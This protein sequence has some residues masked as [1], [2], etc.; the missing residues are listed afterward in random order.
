MGMNDLQF[1]R[2]APRCSGQREAF[3]EICCQLASRSLPPDAAYTRLHG[4]GGDGGVECFA[5]LPDGSRIGWQAKY[6]FRI[7]PLLTQASESLA[8]ALRVH[9]TLTRYIVCFPFNLTGPTERR[10]QSGQERFAEWQRERKDEATAEGRDLTIEAWPESRLTSLLLDHD[11]SG[12]IREFFFNETV[13]SE[14]WFQAHLASVR[15]TAGPRYTPDLSIETD[16]AKWFSAFGRTESWSQALQQRVQPCRT[17]HERLASAADEARPGAWSGTWPKGSREEAQSVAAQMERVLDQCSTLSTTDDPEALSQC[18]GG[19]EGLLGALRS[20]ESRLADDIDEQHGEGKSDSPGFRQFMAEYMCTFPAANLDYVRDTIAACQALD[21]WLQSPSGSLAF[22]GSFVLTGAAGSGKTHGVCDVAHSRFDDGL[23]TCVAFGHAF[24]GEPD[25][26]TRLLESLGLP[27]T[28]GGDG[29]LDALNA[30]A[31]ASGSELLLCIDAIDETRPL[32]YWRDRL[33]AVVEAVRRRAHLRLCVT[34][35]TPFAPYCLPKDH[36]LPTVEHAGFSGMEY[37]ACRGFFEHYG[38]KPP[39]APILQ[40]ELANPLYLRLMCEALQAKGIDRLPA[41][42]LGLSPVIG[43]FL[44]EKEKEFAAEHS[45]NVGAN[46]VAGS[47]R[48]IAGAIAD[49]DVSSLTWSRALEVICEDRPDAGRLPV[50]EWLVRTDLLIE[51]APQTHGPLGDEVSVRPAFERLGDFLIAVE[52]VDR[53]IAAGLDEAALPGGPWHF[54]LTDARAVRQN[55]GVLSALSIIVPEKSPGLELPD[56]VTDAG[57][58][59][60]VLRITI[61]SFPWRA[62]DS[63]SSSSTGLILEGL[64]SEGCGGETIDAALSV[65]WQ[66]STIDAFWLSGRLRSMPLARRDQVWCGYL[67][68]RYESQ[69]PVRRLIDAAFEL[70]LN[71]LEQEVAE[72]WAT[73]LLWFTAAADRRV[74]DRATR[75]AAAIL[76]AKPEV[77]PSVAARMLGCD[78]DEVRERALLSSYGAL[79]VS[80]NT[81]AAHALS[82]QL[83]DAFGEDPTAFDNELNRDD[84]RCIAELARELEALPSGC[85]PE[86]TMQPVGSDWPLSSP[87]DDDID[88]WRLLPKLVRSCQD[89]DFFTYSMGCLLPWEDAV[90]RTDMAKWIV[91]RVAE[92]FGY[93]G[94]GCER[95][96]SYMLGKYGPGRSRPVWAERIGKKLQWIAMYQL[97]SRL[98]DHVERKRDKWTPEPQRTPLILLEERKL[99]PTLPRAMLGEQKRADCWWIGSQADLEAGESLPDAEWIAWEDDLPRFEELLAVREKEAQRW[100][101][102][103]S[104]P[105]WRTPDEEAG[106]DE[107]YRQVW[108]HIESYLIRKEDVA[109]AYDTLHR[110]NFFGRWMPEGGTWLYGL[111]G[112][113][114]WATPFNLAPEEADLWRGQWGQLPVPCV[115]TWTDLA[116][117]WEYDASLP[118]NTTIHV[119]SRALCSPG[120]L[121][122]DG[123]DGYRIVDERT[124]FRDPSVSHKGP[125]ALLADADDLLERLDRLGF[126]LLWTMLGEKL[127]IGGPFGNSVPRRTFSQIARLEDDGAIHIGERA[128]FDDYDQDA[129]PRPA[130]GG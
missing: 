99:D 24:G 4:A 17:P 35:R 62:P 44:E 77:V 34:C 8:T 76:T 39:V 74:K 50:L 98:S 104:Y 2:I 127:I 3:E 19:L 128:F 120:D 100:R 67:H 93:E 121:W 52:L 86:L 65:A 110:R 118:E 119:A 75:A 29:L 113:Y 16:L 105:S 38:L 49:S 90:P 48:A 87:T 109:A 55:T 56:L 78:D 80:R 20:L 21:G 58:R 63:F 129:S 5:D 107:P 43:A 114:P 95:Y 91:Q 84:I 47:L 15:V 69:G 123:R 60:E 66:R 32:R 40:P 33:A 73:L 122:W 124:V 45:T 51:D 106:Q 36:H 70:P 97:A 103:L 27:A 30:A 57:V 88:R 10:G 126:R 13:L 101:L 81:T 54:L 53:G 79:I 92:G 42:W 108:M 61:S 25:P 14:D 85:D 102:L 72:R 6:V 11:R 1:R 117:E 9:P 7:G 111:V 31:E 71:D 12:G 28:L 125:S 112:E 64:G 115:P 59:E 22:E 68:T 130:R 82:A 23:L 18:L 46:I 37:D 89:D 26:W 83:Q 94:S 41:G 96:D 116:V